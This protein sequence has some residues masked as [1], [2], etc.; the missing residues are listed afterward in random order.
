[1]QQMQDVRL[2]RRPNLH[3]LPLLSQQNLPDFL[4]RRAADF[5]TVSF[6]GH[7][8]QVLQEKSRNSQRTDFASPI[9]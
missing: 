7:D 6:S 8:G 9:D 1:M 3:I 2:I 5:T 4:V